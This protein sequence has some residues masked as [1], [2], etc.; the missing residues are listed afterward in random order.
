VF[1]VLSTTATTPRRRWPCEVLINLSCRWVQ[2]TE[3]FDL[4]KDD[5]TSGLR[6]S[7]WKK[8]NA[9]VET[10]ESTVTS[11]TSQPMRPKNICRLLSHAANL[12]RS[13]AIFERWKLELKSD[14]RCEDESVWH[15]RSAARRRFDKNSKVVSIDRDLIKKEPNK[16]LNPDEVVAIGAAVQAQSLPATQV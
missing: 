8:R 5:G 12:K 6:R 3:G 2:K 16:S 4:R 13:R 15:C 9:T 1:E 14:E 11:R 10:V 7:C